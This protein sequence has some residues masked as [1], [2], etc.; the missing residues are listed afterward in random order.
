MT[1]ATATVTAVDSDSAPTGYWRLVGRRLARDRFAFASGV[2]VALILFAVTAGGPLVGLIVGTGP[3]DLHPYAVDESLKP[4]GPWTRVSAATFFT[5]DAAPASG[6][7]VL[8]VLGG[9]GQLGRDELQ[10]VL[11]GGRVSITVAVGA[12]LLSLL[13]GVVLGSAAALLGGT[14]DSVIS[15]ATDFVMSIPLLLFILVV[16]ATYG[17]SLNDITLGFLNQGVV[18]LI[19]LIGC[20]T[21]FYPAR[22]VRASVLELRSREFVEAA[23]M[24]GA[25]ELRIASRHVLPHLWPPLIVLGTLLVATNITLEA[26]LTFLGVGVEAPTASWGQM[27]AETWGTARSPIVFSP[28]QTQVLLTLWP[29]LAIFVTVLALHLLG[30]GLRDALDPRGQRH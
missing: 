17:D 3:N 12:A 7:T 24:L 8:L 19:V 18:A 20:F 25:S 6:R 29:S 22:L 30:E 13:I 10:R 26:G 15:R 2:V 23:R 4:V 14:V 5:D 27:L 16:G 11:Y 21:W 1:A 28:S 9:D